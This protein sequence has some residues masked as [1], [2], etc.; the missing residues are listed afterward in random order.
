MY[1]PHHRVGNGEGEH[2]KVVAVIAAPTADAVKAAVLGFAVVIV[3]FG[4]E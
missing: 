2:V 3:P 1:A 4:Q